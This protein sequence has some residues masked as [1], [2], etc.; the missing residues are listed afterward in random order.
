MSDKCSN[1]HLQNEALARLEK[2]FQANGY[3]KREVTAGLKKKSHIKKV[4]NSKTSCL[5]LDFVSDSLK[6][7]VNKIIQKY[8]F[9]VRLINKPGK[10][11][12]Q[13]VSCNSRTKNSCDCN[14]C[15]ELPP[16]YKCSDRFLVYKFTCNACSSFYIG[17]T[18]R[19]F[20]LR[21][22]EHM[23]SIDK[24][25]KKSALSQ[26]VIEC[27]SDLGFVSFNLNVI[28]QCS[29][30][31][32]T[33]LS[34]ARAIDSFRPSLNRKHERSWWQRAGHS[35]HHRPRR[36]SCAPKRLAFYLFVFNFTTNKL[37]ANNQ[38]VCL[39]YLFLLQQWPISSR[40]LPS[41]TKIYK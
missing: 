37:A 41:I 11:L 40:P 4:N 29:T 32:E 34:E 20:R 39:F 30:P 19:P 25:D 3:Y 10:S 8:D 28:N 18:S 23:S 12:T 5:I 35:A 17:Q 26:H 1:D 22:K 13:A 2:R 33:R 27:H 21:Y 31:L 9:D 6:R 7:K 14:I 15:K 38:G 24:R 36:R 16:K